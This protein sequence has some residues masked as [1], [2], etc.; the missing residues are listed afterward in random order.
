M[1]S[2]S[3]RV[4]FD[5]AGRMGP[6]KIALLEA[7]AE[8]GSISAAGKA[9]GMSYRRAWELV[10]ELNATFGRPLVAPTIGGRH[11]GGSVLTP[12]GAELIEHYRA[13]EAKAEEAA[14]RHLRALEASLAK[15]G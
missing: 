8:H 3:I 10:A 4:D 15:A 14:E 13:I 12:F 2:L 5:G 11:G 9:M 6:G 7:V 1:A